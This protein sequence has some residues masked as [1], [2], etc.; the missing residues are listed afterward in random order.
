MKLI[1]WSCGQPNGERE[2]SCSACGAPLDERMSDALRRHISDARRKLV[3]IYIVEGVV[4]L[5]TLAL[6]FVNIQQAKVSHADRKES[7]IVT[8]TPSPTPTPTPV[9][10]APRRRRTFS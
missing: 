9:K 1:C 6:V 2:K 3:L 8:S 4:L 5:V 7:P 10:K